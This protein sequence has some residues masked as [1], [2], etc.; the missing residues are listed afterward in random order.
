M[1][2]ETIERQLVVDAEDLPEPQR[3]LTWGPE[4]GWSVKTAQ[5]I[6]KTFEYS[7]YSGCGQLT[8]FHV[9][10]DERGT[11]DP[12]TVAYLGRREDDQD[13]EYSRYRIGGNKGVGEEF[14]VKIDLR[15]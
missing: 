12:T 1:D 4:A 11:I 15:A 5:E 8:V 13:Y 14:T 6:A 10:D 9:L 7:H 3:Y 2:N